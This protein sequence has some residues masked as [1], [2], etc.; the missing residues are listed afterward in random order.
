M[1][2]LITGKGGQIAS[3]LGKM[4]FESGI[5][6][7]SVCRRQLDLTDLESIECTIFSIQPSVVINAAGFT[8][9]ESAEVTCLKNL[10]ANSIGAGNLAAVC[11]QNNIPI[12]HLSSDYVFAGDQSSAYIETDE[13]CPI[14]SYGLSKL[15]GEQLVTA[16]N[17]QHVIVRTAWL[18]SSYGKNFVKTMLKLA[19][20]NPEIQ[21][22]N[23]QYGCP[24]YGPDLAGGIFKIVDK[25]ASAEKKHRLWGLYHLVNSGYT[26]WYD[27]AREVF[28]RSAT[29]DGPTAQVIPI[30]TN[31]FGSKVKRPANSRLDCYKIEKRLDISLPSWQIGISGCVTELLNQNS[32]FKDNHE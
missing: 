23:D 24:T 17:P 16:R 13:P 18:H 32:N 22:V 28:A 12:I 11:E 2:I 8:D 27:L 4:A 25:I 26:N 20:N 19:R 5:D 14:N 30:P 7:K 3:C 10:A 1:T 9:V 31:E 6:F 29:L 21:V 15:D